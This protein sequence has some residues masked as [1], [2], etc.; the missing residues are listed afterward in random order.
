MNNMCDITGKQFQT[1][2]VQLARVGYFVAT[3]YFYPVITENLRMNQSV[4]KQLPYSPHSTKGAVGEPMAVSS[5]K[6]PQ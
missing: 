6:F 1:L 4:A 5:H 2:F 3:T